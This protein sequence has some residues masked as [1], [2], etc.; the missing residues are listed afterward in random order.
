MQHMYC[1]IA[2]DPTIHH[3][4]QFRHARMSDEADGSLVLEKLLPSRQVTS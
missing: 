2:V 1:N 3:L 4:R